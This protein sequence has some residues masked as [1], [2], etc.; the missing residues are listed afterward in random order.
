MT[1]SMRAALA[2]V[3]LIVPVLLETI[4]HEPGDQLWGQLVFALTQVV[5]W[6]LVLTV[7]RDLRRSRPAT[8]PARIGS[9]LVV[10]GSIA[11]IGF[12]LLYGVL[13]AVGEDPGV[14][15][16]LFALAFLMLTVGATA[17]CSMP[18]MR[19]RHSVAPARTSKGSIRPRPVRGTQPAA[20]RYRRVRALP[21]DPMRSE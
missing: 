14:S 12:G 11:Q 20:L 15:F 16:I 4:L 6:L 13:A 21:S 8:R 2:A 10:A 18:S 19:S 17:S 5:G 7:C 1:A 9:T 3:L